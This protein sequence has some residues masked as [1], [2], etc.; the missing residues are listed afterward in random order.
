LPTPSATP[1]RIAR[2]VPRS[3]KTPVFTTEGA[4]AIFQHTGRQPGAG[5]DFGKL[6]TEFE[7]IASGYRGSFYARTAPT[8]GE[9]QESSIRK[10]RLAKALL[11][12]YDLKDPLDHLNNIG[13]TNEVYVLGLRI[14][15]DDKRT[16]YLQRWLA[17]E[18][19]VPEV[20][21]PQAYRLALQGLKLLAHC[22]G[23]AA[24]AA[25][26][27]KYPPQAAR[28]VPSEEI[29]LVAALHRL[30]H[31]VTGEKGWYSSTLKGRK[32]GPFVRFVMAFAAHML[33]HL[34]A[35][36]PAAPADLVKN[37]EALSRLPRRVISRIRVVQKNP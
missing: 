15:M 21:L 3:Q 8:P 13:T 36:E 16:L 11:A 6:A 4:K 35:I 31:A 33:A 12:E 2:L 34:D 32:G 1:R 28:E 25:A 17:S 22:E 37:L 20:N 23:L 14:P 7:D 9:D 19:G 29:S 26:K 10:K 30:R 24:D 18:L 5:T 27:K